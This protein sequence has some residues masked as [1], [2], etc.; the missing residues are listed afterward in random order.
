M[1]DIEIRRAKKREW[2][3]KKAVNPAWRA[4]INEQKRKWLERKFAGDEEGL[5]AYKDKVN[6][7]HREWLARH[8]ERVRAYQAKFSAEYKR[9]FYV[10][11]REKILRIRECQA[12]IAVLRDE[13]R[14]LERVGS[15]DTRE[16]LQWGYDVQQVRIKIMHNR[17]EIERLSVKRRKS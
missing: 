7:R 9:R 14:R 11:Q 13:L 16:Y 4:K 1:I 17:E 10:R 2:Y 12:A 6:R 3:R 8:P 5:R 15:L